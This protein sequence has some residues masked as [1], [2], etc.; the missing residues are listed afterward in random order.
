MYRLRAA[1]SEGARADKYKEEKQ[2]CKLENELSLKTK[3]RVWRS[4]S[5][6]I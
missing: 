1:P 5:K 3:V 2:L 4:K 6:G